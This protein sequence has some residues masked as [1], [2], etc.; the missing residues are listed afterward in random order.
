MLKGF[1]VGEQRSRLHKAWLLGGTAAEPLP[2]PRPA[3]CSINWPPCRRRAAGLLS[4]RLREILE[5]IW[6]TS[7]AD[8]SKTNSNTFRHRRTR[9]HDSYAFSRISSGHPDLGF[10]GT[11]LGIT[12]AIAS[13]NPS[14]M[15]GTLTSVTASLGGVFDTT[16]SR[17]GCRLR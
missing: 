12:D 4:R 3:R 17:S 10:L 14:T 16:R 8:N 11:V 15:E 9:L 6:R 2:R 1:D 13:L 5:I 7:S